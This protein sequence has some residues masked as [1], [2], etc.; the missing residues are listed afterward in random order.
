MLK[1]G[2]SV[3]GVA[4]TYVATI[5]GAGYASGQE[6]LQYFSYFR[7]W[8]IC[9]IALASLFFFLFGYLP[10]AL[11]Y[12]FKTQ[13][14]LLAI[15]PSNNPSARLFCDVMITLSLFGT[16]VVML[17]G[18]GTTF[19]QKFHVP[20]FVG[21][22]VVCLLLI[23]NTALGLNMIVKVMTWLTPIMFAGIILVGC[24]AL[25][26]PETPQQ[27]SVPINHSALL[28]N[29]WS[30]GILYVSFNF[31]LAMAILVPMSQNTPQKMMLLGVLLGALLLGGGCFF[32]YAVLESH[33]SQVGSTKLPMVILANQVHAGFGV[34]YVVVLFM[35]L[36]STALTCFYGSVAR[37][38]K[39]LKRRVGLWVIF[40]VA[41]G[42]FFASLLGFKDLVGMIY[43][44]LGYGGILIMGLILF[45]YIFQ[46]RHD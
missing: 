25:L 23:A 17:A 45:V 18:A 3:V 38:S 10:V 30:S 14:Y 16:L 4:C 13:D 9:A 19:E 44:L 46:P 37:L 5:I 2:V 7:E 22:L 42:G 35:G 33:I 20:L 32:L 1:Q 11:A 43:P 31:Q 28:Y 8:G 41:I 40:A 24:Y 21:A 27:T 39:V 36:Y 15:N 29:W 6:I 34:F 26:H 12:R